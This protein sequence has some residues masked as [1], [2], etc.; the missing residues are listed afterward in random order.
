MSKFEELCKLVLNEDTEITEV[1][2]NT[3]DT[4]GVEAAE[5]DSHEIVNKI[6]EKDTKNELTANQILKV[7]RYYDE[8]LG[9]DIGTRI[10]EPEEIE[11]LPEIAPQLKAHRK[12]LSAE[13]PDIPEI[14][15]Y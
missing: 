6:K 9:D 13:I 14:P 5:G 4:K 8:V 3:E 1:T 15:E 10:A 11:D 12:Q 2:E 7:L